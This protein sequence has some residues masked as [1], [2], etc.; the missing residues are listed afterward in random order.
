MKTFN[1]HKWED[2]KWDNEILALV[3]KIHEHKIRQ[4][5]FLKH[6]LHRLAEV[7]K[8]RNT[9]AS[10][11]IEGIT[12]TSA[13]CKQLFAG[14]EPTTAD[15]ACI[16][17]YYKAITLIEENYDTLPL[18]VETI[19]KLHELLYP[20]NKGKFKTVDNC[21]VSVDCFGRQRV[22]FRPLSA[23]ETPDAMENLISEYKKVEPYVDP[24]LLI[25]AF[26]D[27]YL[28]IHPFEDGNG[29][30]SRLLTLLLL[31]KAG[32]MVG[33]YCSIDGAIW[34]ALRSYYA[35]LREAQT[36]W[37][38][39]CNDSISFIKYIL[40]IILSCYEEF[41]L[42]MNLIED[43]PAKELV[44]K[45]FTIQEWLFKYEVMDMLPT[46]GK[47]SIEK[48]LK[49]LCDENYIEKRGAGNRTFYALI[50]DHHPTNYPETSPK[51]TTRK[52]RR[53]LYEK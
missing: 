52:R 14:Q 8:M 1:Y 46:V 49:S 25:P 50:P 37:Y 6:D 35:T 33:R 45:A 34:Q 26:I 17:N 47:K 38:D 48:A 24:L 19:C 43:L 10:N 23:V 9:I 42:H 5:A 12:A 2:A 4:E 41:T 51:A 7:T 11:K 16:A 44:R 18:S 15:E 20:E 31:Y 27:D 28:C 53:K 29:R 3:T 39:G 13:R 22:I 32:Y 30:T 36:D 40:H 21:I